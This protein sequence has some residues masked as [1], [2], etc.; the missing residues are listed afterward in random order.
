MKMWLI[1]KKNHQLLPVNI[2][3]S[4]SNDTKLDQNKGINMVILTQL[5]MYLNFTHFYNNAPL[6]SS[7]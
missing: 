3:I 1:F 2:P 5:Q 4:Y 7:V 6:Y